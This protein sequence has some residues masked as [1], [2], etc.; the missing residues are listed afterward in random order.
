MPV[1]SG[2]RRTRARGGRRSAARRPRCGPCRACCRSCSSTVSATAGSVKLGQP[3][4]ESNLVVG[5]E[6]L[7]AAAGAEVHAVVLGR[8][9][10]AGERRARCPSG[11]ARRTAR[12]SAA[13]AARRRLY[14]RVQLGCAIVVEGSRRMYRFAARSDDSTSPANG[15]PAPLSPRPPPP[16][17]RPVASGERRGGRVGDPVQP[18]PTRIDPVN[19]APSPRSHASKTP[20]T[21]KTLR[22]DRVRW[23]LAH[24]R[25]EPNAPIQNA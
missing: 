12:A 16:H 2:R 1:G 8:T 6:E 20:S 9:V 15:P 19:Q 3:V 7:G 14:G 22:T 13:R 10:R 23:N 5:L 4:P 11:A 24:T 25:A 17:R 21:V 18:R